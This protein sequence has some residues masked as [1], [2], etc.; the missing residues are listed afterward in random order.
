[1]PH[2]MIVL[3]LYMYINLLNLS[4]IKMSIFGEYGA[5]RHVTRMRN[6]RNERY[7]YV[8]LYTVEPRYLEL[9]Y[10]ELPLISK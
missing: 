2:V 4:W 9:A 5:V 1:M 10:F 3:L 7:V 6:L 8:P